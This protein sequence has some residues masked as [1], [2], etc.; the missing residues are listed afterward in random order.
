[1]KFYQWTLNE[2]HCMGLKL[3]VCMN[4]FYFAWPWTTLI[5]TNVCTFA[6]TISYS[7]NILTCCT[8]NS[9]LHELLPLWHSM[10]LIDAVFIL[11]KS[12]TVSRLKAY[13]NPPKIPLNP[14]NCNTWH[15]YLLTNLTTDFNL[16]ITPLEQTKVSEHMLQSHLLPKS[17]LQKRLVQA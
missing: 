8:K 1:M 11:T 3:H 14:P 10:N 13:Y 4:T 5:C 16:A 12:C 15:T 7:M 9:T 17:Y 6:W 2:L